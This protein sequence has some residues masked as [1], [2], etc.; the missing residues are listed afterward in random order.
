MVTSAGGTIE[1]EGVLIQIP[2]SA[3]DGIVRIH[4]VVVDKEA[5][6][7]VSA[8]YSKVYE[9]TK[10]V[11]G[12]F[13]QPIRLTLP[14]EAAP[15]ELEALGKRLTMMWLN[16]ETGE[17]VEL[18]DVEVDWT[19]LTVTGRTDHFTKFAILAAE[20]E[21]EAG[22]PVDAVGH[23]AERYIARMMEAGLASEE[24]K[25]RYDPDRPVTRAEFVS[26]ILGALPARARIPNEDWPPFADVAGHEAAAEI[27]EAAARGI[28]EGY[29]DG[30]F[31]PDDF[32]LREEMTALLARS[33]G[34]AALAATRTFGDEADISAWARDA[35]FSASAR[36]LIEG[37]DKGRF[38]PRDEA[39]RAETAAVI[40]RALL[41]Q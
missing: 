38:R 21:E 37:D 11:Q 30:T 7:G 12:R 27:A 39:T 41:M 14:F 8:V 22:I 15:E 18:D 6:P 31:R 28:V 3:V 26:L 16:E 5:L 2:E 32:L 36:G 13:A 24:S 20:P 19:S 40:I 23:W 34:V 9:I 29:G 33:L 10:D 17:W 1:L 25:V 4:V 35:V